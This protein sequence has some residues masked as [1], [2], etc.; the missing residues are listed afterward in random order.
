MDYTLNG[1]QIYQQKREN[2][3]AFEKT[4]KSQFL[5]HSNIKK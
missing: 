3:S 4:V 5:S 2:E 1:R